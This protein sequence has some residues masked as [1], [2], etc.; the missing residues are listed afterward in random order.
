MSNAEL[1]DVAEYRSQ[2]VWRGQRVINGLTIGEELITDD[3]RSCY[4]LN[5]SESNPSELLCIIPNE[6][7]RC[8]L[9]MEFM[10]G[11]KEVNEINIVTSIHKMDKPSYKAHC[12]TCS[13]LDN[14]AFHSMLQTIK[15]AKALQEAIELDQLTLLIS[16]EDFYQKCNLTDLIDNVSLPDLFSFLFRCNKCLAEYSFCGDLYHGNVFWTKTKL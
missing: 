16:E 8:P 1:N 9:G 4:L 15:F 7:V 13:M 11:I 6:M 10:I 5:N 2:L 3:G 14:R 12:E